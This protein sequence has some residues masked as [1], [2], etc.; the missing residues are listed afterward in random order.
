MLSSSFLLFLRPVP[1]FLYTCTLSTTFHRLYELYCISHSGRIYYNG[2]VTDVQEGRT[3]AED[4]HVQR[5]SDCHDNHAPG[6]L[7]IFP[8]LFWI[9]SQGP[10]F[11]QQ[12][13]LWSKYDIVIEKSN[14]AR[15]KLTKLLWSCE[16]NIENLFTYR[17]GSQ[18]SGQ[19]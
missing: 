5:S 18:F 1:L 7:Q 14:E 15:V 11:V 19:N 12:Q 8:R 10:P 13:I 9:V 3:I 6:H 4:C 2:D 17:K 16:T